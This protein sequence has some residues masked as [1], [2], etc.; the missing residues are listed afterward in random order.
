MDHGKEDISVQ[1]PGASAGEVS[2]RSGHL[3]NPCTVDGRVWPESGVWEVAIASHIVYMWL[4]FF[5]F[6]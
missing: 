6:P 4:F 3:L 1:G 5:L 2:A